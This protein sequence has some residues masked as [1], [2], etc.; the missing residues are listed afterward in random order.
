[1][2][3]NII[4]IR[5]QTGRNIWASRSWVIRDCNSCIM[6][7]NTEILCISSKFFLYVSLIVIKSYL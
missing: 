4:Q 6:N 7:I 3:K 2:E 1:M 5:P